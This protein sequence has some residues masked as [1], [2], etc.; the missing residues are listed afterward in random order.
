[1]VE[2]TPSS[3]RVLDD[4]EYDD[5]SITCTASA[6]ADDTALVIE[7]IIWERGVDGVNFQPVPVSSYTTSGNEDDGYVSILEGSE[8]ITSSSVQYQCIASVNTANDL[9]SSS[10]STVTVSGQSTLY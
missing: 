1:M 3:I 8:S 6:N 2:T 5:F 4:I 10:T 7:D 9:S